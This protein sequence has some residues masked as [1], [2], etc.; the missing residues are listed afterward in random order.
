MSKYVPPSL[1]NNDDY[2]F[3]NNFSLWRDICN[4]IKQ[5]GYDKYCH[6]IQKPYSDIIYKLQWPSDTE[7]EE[8]KNAD[9]NL[10]G[11]TGKYIPFLIRG[12]VIDV[13]DGTITCTRRYA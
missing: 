11:K 1:L 8:F 4:E 6:S 2:D 12:I 10:T 5:Y 13:E 7:K 9:Y 3:E